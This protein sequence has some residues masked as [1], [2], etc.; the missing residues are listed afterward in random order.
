MF[1]DQFKAPFSILAPM[2]GVT[3]VVFR[4]VVARA[5]RPDIFFTEFTNVY[6][7]ANE[8]GRQNALERLKFLPSEQ[9]IVAQIWGKTPENF[10]LMAGGLKELGYLAVDINTGCPDK[11]VVATGGGSALIKSPELTAEII[12]A[13]KTSGLEVSVKTRLGY[14]KVEE[15]KT[16]LPFLFQQDLKALSIHLRTKKEMSKV[17]SHFELIPEIVKMRDSIAPQTKL[18]FNGD[19]LDVKTGL[20]MAEEHG[21]DGVMIGRGVFQNPFCFT[22]HA[23]TQAELAEL[24][25]Y[26]IDLWEEYHSGGDT[27]GARKHFEPLKRFFKIYIHGVRGAHDLRA[28]LMETKSINQVREILKREGL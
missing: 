26:H 16:W 22:D 12:S 7:Y 15:Y 25:H 21:F 1:W 18:I 5:S 20:A 11:N 23:P 3:D 13:T 28:E 8:I 24:L 4:Q 2:E 6:S 10:S 14:S 19:I 9:P 27:E 17:A